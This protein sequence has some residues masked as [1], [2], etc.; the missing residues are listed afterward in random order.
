MEGIDVAALSA[1]DALGLL[2]LVLQSHCITAGCT[3]E[4]AS[5][6]TLLRR[7]LHEPPNNLER[8]SRDWAMH[9]VAV[10]DNVSQAVAHVLDTLCGLVQTPADVFDK[11]VDNVDHKYVANFGEEVARGHPLYVS[12]AL[13]HKIQAD[14][15]AAAG[16]GPWEVVSAGPDT[17][18]AVGR[19]VTAAL[20]DMQG[21]S[22]QPGAAARV[23]LSAELGGLEDVPPGVIAVLT[24][25]PVKFPPR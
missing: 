24:T 4:A 10:L 12:S 16:L 19:V 22:V 14:V 7:L 17:G 23:V 2:E 25:S 3:P 1:D 20:S 11:A 13:L 5:A 18:V 15:R 6:H 9:A 8:W 21:E